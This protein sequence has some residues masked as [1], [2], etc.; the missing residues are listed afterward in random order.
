MP[1]HLQEDRQPH[2]LPIHCLHNL[3]LDL[4][5]V[6]CAQ[7]PVPPVFSAFKVNHENLVQEAKEKKTVDD[8]SF[9]LGLLKGLANVRFR[10]LGRIRNA[11]IVGNCGEGLSVFHIGFMEDK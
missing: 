2:S 6:E 3:D 5:L 9:T 7:H 8:L 1:T 11:K 4:L 10:D